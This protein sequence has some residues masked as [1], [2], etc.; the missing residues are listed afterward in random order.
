MQRYSLLGVA[1]FC[2]ITVSA[3]DCN[4]SCL[5]DTM[6]KYLA[7][8]VAQDPSKAPLAPNLRFTEDSKDLKAGEG[9]W[10]LA[11]KLGDYRQDFI[12]V[13]QQVVQMKQNGASPEQLK[14]FLM[15]ALQQPNQSKGTVQ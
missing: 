2:S 1:L 10:K 4:R 13:K 14:A 7:A 5:K 3:A 11:T 8:L 12:D 9:L 6:T 15:Q